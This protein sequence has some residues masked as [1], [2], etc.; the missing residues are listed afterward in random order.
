MLM[1]CRCPEGSGP[2][3]SRSLAASRWS[4]GRPKEKSPCHRDSQ[5]IDVLH[6]P[7]FCKRR[8]A[9]SQNGWPLLH[10]KNDLSSLVRSPWT[11]WKILK[12]GARACTWHRMSAQSLESSTVLWH[13][14]FRGCVDTQAQDAATHSLLLHQSREACN[15]SLRFQRLPWCRFRS[16]LNQALDTRSHAPASAANQWSSSVRC[17]MASMA[18]STC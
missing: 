7:K 14:G 17:L 6:V 9:I 8:M 12:I 4:L 10:H 3:G 13:Y 16:Q 1:R 11:S 2:C 18:Y 15:E 5:S